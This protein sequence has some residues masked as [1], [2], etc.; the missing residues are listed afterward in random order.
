[1]GF[2]K[3]EGPSHHLIIGP[4]LGLILCPCFPGLR[5]LIMHQVVARCGAS[6]FAVAKKLVFPNHVTTPRYLFFSSTSDSSSRIP[7]PSSSSAPSYGQNDAQPSPI[8][9]HNSEQVANHSTSHAE[10]IDQQSDTNAANPEDEG[11]HPDWL[12]LERRVKFRKPKP[13]G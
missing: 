7:S 10:N 4:D 2:H 8:I 9:N 13:L 6:R 5:R 11:I 1:M 12:A 3:E